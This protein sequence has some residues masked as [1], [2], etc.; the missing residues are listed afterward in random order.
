MCRCPHPTREDVVD[1]NDL[2]IARRCRRCSSEIE[3]RCFVCLG[4]FRNLEAHHTKSECGP[5]CLAGH[6][7]RPIPPTRAEVTIVVNGGQ[8]ELAL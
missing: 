7:W 3:V 8:M 4:W 1:G 6:W 5:H 2:L